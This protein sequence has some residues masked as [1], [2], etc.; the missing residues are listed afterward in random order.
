MR[1][2]SYQPPSVPVKGTVL[3]RHCAWCQPIPDAV[4]AAALAAGRPYTGGICSSCR[5]RVMAERAAKHA[6]KEA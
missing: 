4:Q 3:Q 5:T 2:E 6:G 1:A